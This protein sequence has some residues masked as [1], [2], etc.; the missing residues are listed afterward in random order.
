MITWGWEN[1]FPVV[2]WWHIWCIKVSR[3]GR[4]KCPCWEWGKGYFLNS[5]N[6]TKV[7]TRVPGPC[8]DMTKN[9]PFLF[10]LFFIFLG[11]DRLP[12]AC[13]M[14]SCYLFFLGFS[15]LFF[16]E[17]IFK[18]FLH[19]PPPVDQTCRVH[20]FISGNLLRRPCQPVNVALCARI[21]CVDGIINTQ[22]LFGD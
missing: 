3:F 16:K 21:P 2:N 6:R 4:L 9:V 14:S 1:H 17:R 11:H 5:H 18:P 20:A 8:Q 12:V 7:L 15:R 19:G 22:I 13:P 10:Y